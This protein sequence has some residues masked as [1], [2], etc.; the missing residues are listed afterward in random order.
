MSEWHLANQALATFAVDPAALGGLW[1]RARSGPV[2]D[3][4]IAALTKAVPTRRLS[5]LADDAQLYGGLDVA[6]TL[7]ASKPVFASG[8]L[9]QGGVCLVPMAE[10]IAP[11]LAGRLGMALDKGG[12]SLIALDEGIDDEGLPPALQDR[13]AIP[14]S[15]DGLSAQ[16]C[17]EITPPDIAAARARLAE[18][19]LPPET[20]AQLTA[21]AAHMGIDSLRVPLHALRVAR[22]RLALGDE[23]EAALETA[24]RLTLAPRMTTPP[25]VEQEDETEDDTPPDQ[26]EDQGEQDEQSQQLTD[27]ELLL[28]AA[29]AL[30]P[31]DGEQN[32]P[33]RNPAH[34][35]PLA[36]DAA[37]GAAQ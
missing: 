22:A 34:R 30:L 26:Q 8:I 7:A 32:R 28:E 29:K 5:P 15:L 19:A 37:Q 23:A 35:R 10:R 2:R 12:L 25:P 11:E 4:F 6:A 31:D 1:I 18:V 21:L 33:A 3:R 36:T 20:L 14:L 17:P 27:E 16:D 24:I 9:A 13:L